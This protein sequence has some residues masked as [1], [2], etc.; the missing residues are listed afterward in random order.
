MRRRF[1]LLLLSVTLIACGEAGGNI[2]ATQTRTSELGV[3][4]TQTR[5]IELA[6]LAT[7]NVLASTTVQRT[8]ESV[9]ICPKDKPIKG[10]TSETGEKQYEI[11]DSA[12]YD[13]I[14]AEACFYNVSGAVV[15][16]YHQPS[17]PFRPVPTATPIVVAEDLSGTPHATNPIATAAP[18][19]PS[20]PNALP[21]SP[22]AS[23][24]IVPTSAAHAPG[25]PPTA[26][27]VAVRGC[28]GG[29]VSIRVNPQLEKDLVQWNRIVEAANKL[30][31]AWNKYA[32]DTSAITTFDD[33]AGNSIFVA[34]VDAVLAAA[35]EQLPIFQAEAAGGRFATLAEKHRADTSIMIRYLSLLR[36][37]A[38]TEDVD[39][40]NSAIDVQDELDDANT[41]LDAEVQIQCAFWRSQH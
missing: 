38:A 15:A 4:A 7:V 18:S 22:T 11:P 21:P 9:S 12:R 20:T 6:Q 28:G 8:P 32:D 2:Q 41:A 37:V 40:W 27:A 31:A 33:A 29:I 3:F 16:G 39:T 34:S 19:N 13:E 10:Y 36:D 35:Q 1:W 23:Q 24:P 25:P 30:T 26:E 5:D 17:E 14:R